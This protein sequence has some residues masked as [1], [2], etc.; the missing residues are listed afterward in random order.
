[1]RLSMRLAGFPGYTPSIIVTQDIGKYTCRKPRERWRDGEGGRETDM[2]NE[3]KRHREK[4][5]EKEK[6]RRKEKEDREREREK[7]SWER[8]KKKVKEEEEK[9]QRQTVRE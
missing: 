3:R 4:E 6:E 5:S 1:M 8:E 2:G 9:T 7:W